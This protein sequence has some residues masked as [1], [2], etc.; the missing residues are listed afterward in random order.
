MQRYLR[1]ILLPIF[2]A[3]MFITLQGQENPMILLKG[4][5]VAQETGEALPFATLVLV[6]DAQR[7]VATDIEGN[8]SWE[9]SADLQSEV[10]VRYIGYTT[11]RLTVG[12]IQKEGII[13]LASDGASIDPLIVRAKINYDELY[14]STVRRLEQDDLWGEDAINIARAFDGLPGVQIQQGALN[15][16]RLSLR[17]IGARTPFATDQVRLYWNDFPLTNGAGESVLEDIESGFLE[18]AYVQT[19]PAPAALGANLGGSIQLVSKQWDLPNWGTSFGASAGDFGRNR[20]WLNL[21]NKAGKWEQDL[22]LV[23]SASAG[24]RDNN[25][26]ERF[27]GT[28]LGRVG[29]RSNE[30]LYLVHLRQMK[31][32]IPSSLNANDFAEKPTAAAFNW[33][34]VNGREDQLTYLLGLQHTHEMGSLGRM[35][36]LINRSSV[37]GGR[38]TNDEVR[39][40]NIIKEDSYQYGLRTNFIFRDAPALKGSFQAGGELFLENYD[41]TTFQVL[42]GGAQGDQLG[43]QNENRCYYFAFSQWTAQWGKNW[44]TTLEGNVRQTLY[45]WQ[46]VNLDRDFN[47]DPVLLPSFSIFYQPNDKNWSLHARV[48]RG[49]SQ[50]DPSSSIQN[51]LLD[52]EP[53]QAA[54]GWN[55]EVG[56]KWYSNYFYLEI[57]AFQMDLDDALVQRQDE[58]GQVLF[59]N[60]GSARHQGL[61]VR[62]A[63]GWW[64]EEHFLHFKTNYT[65]A[66]YRFRDFQELDGDYSGNDIPGVHPHRWRS[67]LSWKTNRWGASLS[68]DVAAKQWVDDANTTSADGFAVVH[69]RLSHLFPNLG[70]GLKLYAGCNNVFDQAYAGM[71]QVNASG[72]G[73]NLPRYFYPA[74]PRYFYLGVDY[75]L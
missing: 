55:R 44:K 16:Q 8:F 75:G 24:Y 67:D 32:E 58:L 27:S 69:T 53:L 19:G 12:A 74:L 49:I 20:E 73:S 65:L 34:S 13:E 66:D 3:M 36:K 7:G 15:T 22:S 37:F 63:K 71:V 47:F 30:T 64:F 6:A 42:A 10:E 23:R 52:G 9:V 57:T 26:Y 35:G 72:F 14:S 31:A 28:L 61:E 1:L 62:F 38:R 2:G 33:A 25:D 68:L 29:N 17:G 43:S 60:G 45:S 18:M 70:R 51:S 21:H 39:P 4:K 56:L 48:N 46:A 5:V 11:R 59:F 50:P 54:T 41:I 40:F